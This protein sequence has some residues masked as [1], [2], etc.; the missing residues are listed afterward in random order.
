MGNAEGTKHV[1]PKYMYENIG[2]NF[3][4]KHYNHVTHRRPLWKKR[5]REYDADIVC[6]QEVQES[7]ANWIQEALP[8]YMIWFKS[9]HE[10]RYWATWV[11]A[12]QTWEHN[13][14]I[15]LVKRDSPIM[16]QFSIEAR[17]VNVS[18]DGCVAGILT[19]RHK[20]C[21]KRW[22]LG[23][24]SIANVHLAHPTDK[25]RAEDQA[26]VLEDTIKKIGGRSIVCGDFNSMTNELLYKKYKEWGYKD[27]GEIYNQKRITCTTCFVREGKEDRVLPDARIDYFM[28]KGVKV[29]AM[30]EKAPDCTAEGKKEEYVLHALKYCGSDHLPLYMEGLF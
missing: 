11:A 22:W 8:E 17:S 24:I 1:V 27:Q 20:S 13:G 26:K 18:E 25:T 4:K 23:P 2:C 5:I 7:E 30:E 12:H 10:D 16:Q 3:D 21:L 15:Y 14:N 19:L 9:W 6:L 28:T 29:T